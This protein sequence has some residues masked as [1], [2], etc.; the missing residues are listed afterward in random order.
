MRRPCF[1]GD[2]SYAMGS[3]DDVCPEAFWREISNLGQNARR[4]R[5][6]HRTNRLTI[7]ASKPYKSIPDVDPMVIFRRWGLT[8]GLARGQGLQL[9]S[10][11]SGV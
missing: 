10:R 6:S 11:V 2:E 8:N 3:L 1:K 7:V 4:H 9:A 5:E